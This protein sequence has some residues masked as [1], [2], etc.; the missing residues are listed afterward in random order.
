V[1]RGYSPRVDA[2]LARLGSDLTGEDFAELALACLDQSDIPLDRQ[3]AI[4]EL[5]R[6]HG[7]GAAVGLKFEIFDVSYAGEGAAGDYFVVTA[8]ISGQTPLGTYNG[9]MTAWYGY[10]SPDGAGCTLTSTGWS[11]AEQWTDEA[12]Y[13]HLGCADAVRLGEAILAAAVVP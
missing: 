1:S 4:T 6:G 12:M 5:V 10:V 2:L 3:R 11:S 8:R 13:R 7:H 9:A